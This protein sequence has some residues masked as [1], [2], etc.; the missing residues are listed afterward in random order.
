MIDPQ[1]LLR[2]AKAFSEA[3]D[4]GILIR[5]PKADPV[6]IAAFL[7]TVHEA[8]FAIQR[9]GGYEEAKEVA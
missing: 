1:E 3:F 7:G 2:L 8:R 5:N 9:A 4:D 6:K